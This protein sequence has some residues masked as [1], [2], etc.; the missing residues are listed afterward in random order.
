[1]RRAWV[2][3]VL[4]ATTACH[5]GTTLSPNAPTTGG[6]ATVELAR[7]VHQKWSPYVGVHI[8][9]DA[10]LAY[11]DALSRLQR[12]GRLRGVRV[13][14]S[15]SQPL[16]DPLIRAIGGLGVDLLG[17]IGNEYL[18]EANIER[19]ID[20]I[21]AAYPEIRYFQL[22]NEV[23]TILPATGPTIT[24]E[25]YM[26]VFRRVYDHVQS[27]H[28]GRAVLLT[29]STLGSGLRGPAEL[30]LMATSL[31]PGMDRNAVI[32]A[33]NAYDPDAVSLYRGVLGGPLSGFRVWV[34]ESGVADPSL[35]ISFVQ[36]RYPRLRDFLRAE[37]V[38]WYVLWGGDSGLDTDFS[39]IRNPGAFPNYWKSPLFDLLTGGA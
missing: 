20:R 23:T 10:R 6:S 21:F 29:Q 4:C 27:R 35:H 39:L 12:A 30:E 14:I 22:G 31:F 37:R 9:G 8:T 24:I 18:F 26:A 34:T 19:E 5:D 15:R 2:W 38:Y 33:V 32:I 17:L 36:Q 28:H 25:E 1:M 7:D 16:G 11:L 3:L 13:E